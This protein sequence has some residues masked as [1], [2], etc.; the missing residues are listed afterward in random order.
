MR[1]ADFYILT[2]G[3]NERKVAKRVNGYIYDSGR[4]VYG[5]EKRDGLCGG[6]IVSD[7]ATGLCVYQPPIIGAATRAAAIE[8]ITPQIEDAVIEMQLTKDGEDFKRIIQAAY[9]ADVENRNTTNSNETNTSSESKEEKTMNKT[10]NSSK[11]YFDGCTTLE[12]LRTVYKNLL[13]ANHPDNGGDV[14]TMQEINSQYGEAF[15]RLK[16]GAVIENDIDKR[17]W[18]DVEDQK[19]RE[20]LEKIIF[21]AGLNVEIV[22]SWIWVDGETFLNRDILKAAGYKWSNARKKWHFTP[23]EGGYH[24]GSKKSFDQLRRQYGSLEVEGAARQAIA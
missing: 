24:R 11:A 18:S 22:G 19:I 9:N 12:Q 10:T 16:S 21:C 4:N 8:R 17:K 15:K 7:L 23:Y 1:K 2:F 6:W 20:A 14:A 13:K 3:R 5:I